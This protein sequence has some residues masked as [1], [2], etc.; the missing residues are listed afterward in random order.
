MADYSRTELEEMK[1]FELRALC[2]ARGL[3]GKGF[4]RLRKSDLVTLLLD[5]EPSSE[6][7]PETLDDLEPSGSKWGFLKSWYWTHIYGPAGLILAVVLFS[8]PQV[9]EKTRQLFEEDS[10]AFHR[11]EGGYHVLILPFALLQNRPERD[12]ELEEAIKRRLLTVSEEKDLGLKVKYFRS[13]RYPGTFEDGREFGRRMK[14]DLVIWGDVYELDSDEN[15]GTLKYA[16]V[17]EAPL[18]DRLA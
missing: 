8:F 16:L 14:A 5:Q 1:V 3:K 12:I 6:T 10:G 7:K 11:T 4:W 15:E 2:E 9:R 18:C 13:K 17:N